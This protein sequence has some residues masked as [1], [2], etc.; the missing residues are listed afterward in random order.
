[1]IWSPRAVWAS[2]ALRA[3]RRAEQ[4][5]AGAR[6]DPQPDDGQAPERAEHEH[7]AARTP[8]DG[9]SPGELGE[10]QNDEEQRVE[11]VL[12]D[13]VD[14]CLHMDQRRAPDKAAGEEYVVRARGGTLGAHVRRGMS[15]GARHGQTRSTASGRPRSRSGSRRAAGPLDLAVAGGRRR[16]PDR[17]RSQAL[18]ARE[19]GPRIRSPPPRLARRAP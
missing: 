1:M 3:R 12:V 4:E 19:A 18:E 6:N 7:S 16:T 5:T 13:V 10:R 14:R 9:N 11:P 2:R 8:I 17:D 15:G